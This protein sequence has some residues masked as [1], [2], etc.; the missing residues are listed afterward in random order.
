M[1]FLLT[2]SW[3]A[4]LL[5]AVAFAVV[6]VGLGVWQWDRR[7]ARLE[8][9]QLVVDNYRQDPA[10]ARELV[11]APGGSFPPGEEWRPVEA[12]GEYLTT[13]TTLLR[14]RPLDGVNGFHV[15]VP[16]LLDEPLGDGGPT[17]LLVDRGFLPAGDDAGS[18][19]VPAA[20]AGEVS[21]VVH[22]RPGEPA[23]GRAP[24][25]QTRS[26]DLPAIAGSGCVAPVLADRGATLVDAAY[27][28]LVDEAPSAS[29]AP[30]L[31]PPPEVDEG[32]HLSYAFQWWVFALGGF[33]GYGVVA[34]R[35]AADLRAE[36]AEAGADGPPHP[37]DVPAAGD[38][39]RPG[40]R[41][42]TGAR[43]VRPAGA[44][45]T[46]RRPTAEEE[47]D[48]LVDAAERSRGG[49]PG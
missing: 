41:T 4:G 33:V 31:L 30:Q 23:Y 44:A 47:E 39:R 20:P 43:R 13:A 12:T 21:V 26:L 10:S 25:C 7:I 40:P 22:L 32:P 35:H 19:D 3:V 45:A 49:R 15:L 28:E 16:L 34:R 48:A 9:N 8:A 17:A 18:V 2:R 37:Q 36:R 24:R 1:R 11:P 14:Q 38:E 42:P 5:A 46:R 6:C 29:P 27:G